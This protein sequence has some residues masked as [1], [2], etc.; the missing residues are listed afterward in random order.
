M[1]LATLTAI[2]KQY[3]PLVMVLAGVIWYLLREKKEREARDAERDK[4]DAEQRDK[5]GNRIDTLEDYIKGELMTMQR[6]TTAAIQAQTE[7]NRMLAE[8]NNALRQALSLVPCLNI[9]PESKEE[10][11]PC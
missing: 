4:R 10:K 2:G 3:G 5:L 7:T 6:E 1:D 11:T 8:S 9:K